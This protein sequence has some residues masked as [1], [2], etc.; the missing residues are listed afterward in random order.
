LTKHRRQRRHEL[1]LVR[2]FFDDPMR[3]VMRATEVR[4]PEARVARERQLRERL[5]ALRALL[6][7]ME[8]EMRL[9]VQAEADRASA[10]AEAPSRPV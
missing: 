7:L 8:G 3:F 6:D 1:A 2:S 5:E 10:T 9:L 4:T